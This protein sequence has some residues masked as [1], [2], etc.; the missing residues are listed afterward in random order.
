MVGEKV[1]SNFNGV[2]LKVFL[3]DGMNLIPCDGCIRYLSISVARFDNAAG[4]QAFKLSIVVNY[5]EC[6]K[7]IVP[8]FNDG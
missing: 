8:L 6:A 2:R 1:I 3:T 7:A 4:K 5:W